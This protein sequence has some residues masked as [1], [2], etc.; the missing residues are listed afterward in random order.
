MAAFEILIATP[1]VR[2]LIRESKSHQI[3]S[4]LQTSQ[5]SGMISFDACLANLVKRKVVSKEEAESK[6]LNQDTFHKEMEQISKSV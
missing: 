3:S 2:N 5:Q 1:S 6:A 4:I